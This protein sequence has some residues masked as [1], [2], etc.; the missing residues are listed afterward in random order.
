MLLPLSTYLLLSPSFLTLKRTP[1]AAGVL[2]AML[3]PQAASRPAAAALPSSP[4]FQEDLALRGLRF[5]DTA[6]QREA[7]QKVG[8]A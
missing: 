8:G 4:F 7:A 3:S 1:A 6:M 2:R 5:L